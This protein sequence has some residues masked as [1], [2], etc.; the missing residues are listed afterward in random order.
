MASVALQTASPQDHGALAG[1]GDDDHAQ[2]LLLAGRAGG[3]AAI[4]GTGASEELNLRGSS[5]ANLGLI[6]SQSPIVFDDQSAA[7][8][9]SPYFVQAIPTQSFSGVFIGGGVDMSPTVTFTGG[10]FIWEGT[11]IA[12]RITSG[13]TPGFAAF[14][15]LNALPVLTGAATGNNPLNALTLNVGVTMENSG[16]VVAL[17]TT[18][19]FGV[20]FAPQVRVT[21]I[22]S[23][24][25]V[26]NQTAVSC[27]PTFSTINSTT[28]NLGTIRGLHAQEPAVA[29]FQPAAGTETM[30]AYYGVDVD[31]MAFGGNVPKAALRSSLTAASNSYFLLNA[32]NAQSDFGGGSILN[33]S[34]IQVLTD[35]FGLSLGAAGGDVQ[36]LWDGSN[37]VHNPIIGDNLEIGYASGIHTLGS[38]TFNNSLVEMMWEK[39]SF[40]EVGIGNQI[41]KWV[42]NARETLANGDW[43]DFLQTH[44][45]NLTVNHTMA[46]ITVWAINPLSITN[47]TGTVGGPVCTLLMGGMT[48]SNLNGQDTATI[49]VTG[50]LTQRGTVQYTPINPANITANQTAWAGLLSGSQ[51]NSM[52]RWARIT[53]NAGLSIQGILAT[54]AQDGDTY[55]LTNV[56]ANTITLTDEDAGAAAADRIATHTSANVVLGLEETITIRYD[57]TSARWRTLGPN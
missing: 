45:A 25:T 24:M 40:G 36:I 11:K 15:L 14:T 32:G 30:T 9:L 5:N 44:A 57:A 16:V 20:S 55:D 34:L 4:G 2:Y 35:S 17:T 48:T 8:A 7:N 23:T 10:T 52:R 31:A 51:S 18:S 37:E 38:A 54:V 29:L 21:G 41:G 53:A 3:Q 49:Q 1:L 28:A 26:L 42:T 33:A 47:G 12:P 43:T 46:N 13:V 19:N 6:R 50:R 22:F 56:G 39:F 27:R